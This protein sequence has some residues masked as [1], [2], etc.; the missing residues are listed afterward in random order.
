MRTIGGLMLGSII[1]AL[2]LLIMFNFLLL[3]MMLVG[4]YDMIN[5]LL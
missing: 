2:I 4:D 5:L 3:I 1:D